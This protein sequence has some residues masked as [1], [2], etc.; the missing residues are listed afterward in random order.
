MFAKQNDYLI[1]EA[2]TQPA[3]ADSSLAA[4][5]E[6]MTTGINTYTYYVTH[7]LLE[8]WIELPIITPGQMRASRNIRY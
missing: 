7:N 8:E 3:Y 5:V 2:L 1:I 4:D 6:P